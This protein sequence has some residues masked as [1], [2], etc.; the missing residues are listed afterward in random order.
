MDT[1]PTNVVIVIGP[2]VV[3]FDAKNHKVVIHH[4]DPSPTDA[5]VKEGVS[6]AL[7]DVMNAV[8]T[9]SVRREP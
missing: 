6:V 2:T 3:I 8:P 9:A 5:Q 7:R 1:L 4:G